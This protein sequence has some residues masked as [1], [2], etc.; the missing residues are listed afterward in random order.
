MTASDERA[1][2]PTNLP[3]A[4]V[5]PLSL[6]PNLELNQASQLMLITQEKKE[7]QINQQLFQHHVF[8]WS[9]LAGIA[10]VATVSIGLSYVVSRYV[11]YQRRPKPPVPPANEA[12]E[13]LNRLEENHLPLRHEF[14]TYYVQLTSII[15][16]Y[17]ERQATIP[18][19][20]QTTQEFLAAAAQDPHFNTEARQILD[21]LL[22][23]ADQVKFAQ[24]PSTEADCEL[25]FAYAR[26]FLRM[27]S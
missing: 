14:D 17:I 2:D 4:D 23:Y 5:L 20:T 1:I 7:P 12:L 19:S 11:T 22:T 10:L 16:R 18:A 8:P 26:E 15:R 3:K 13:A 24:K 9:I 27:T 25:A 6:S 21:D